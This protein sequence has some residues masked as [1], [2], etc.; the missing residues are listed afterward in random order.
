MLARL[1]LT[2]HAAQCDGHPA[3]EPVAAESVRLAARFMDRAFRH[4]YA[5]YADTFADGTPL[6][7]A[8]ATARA[9]VAAGLSDFNRR[10]LVHSSRAFR[11]AVPDEQAAA[12]RLLVDYAWLM[13]D[14]DAGFGHGARWRVQSR[15]HDLFRTE[16]E[17]ARGATRCARREAAR[18]SR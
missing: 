5:I 10:D 14:A 13:P 8:R 9:I 6:S 1:A 11:G 16:G 7:L 15:A 3:A 2:F 12:L 4:A 18:R 17:T